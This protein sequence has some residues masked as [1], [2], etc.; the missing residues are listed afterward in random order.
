M[1]SAGDQG[2]KAP[3]TNRE[4]YT[5]PRITTFVP[6]YFSVDD[7][8]DTDDE[9]NPMTASVSSLADTHSWRFKSVSNNMITSFLLPQGIVSGL[10][11]DFVLKQIFDRPPCVA[12]FCSLTIIF[13][14][15][16]S[17]YH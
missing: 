10:D 1:T 9:V 6:C 8:T 12:Y 16:F 7:F 5:I 14:Q 11:V 4:L 2:C 13:L 17:L 15:P 3:K